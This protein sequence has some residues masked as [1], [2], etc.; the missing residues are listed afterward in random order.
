MGILVK[1]ADTRKKHSIENREA[2]GIDPLK[3]TIVFYFLRLTYAETMYD[4]TVCI[5]HTETDA[6]SSLN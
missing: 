1:Q 5:Q 2:R 4:I 6:L 3:Y